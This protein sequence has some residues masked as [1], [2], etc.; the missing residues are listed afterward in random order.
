MQTHESPRQPTQAHE[1]QQRKAAAG[2]GQGSRRDTSRAFQVC[3]FIAFEKN[4]L[5][6]STGVA[7]PQCRPMQAHDSPRQ[8]SHG[9]DSQRKPTQAH[10]SQRS[11][12]AAE[13][14]QGSRRDT[15]QAFQVCFFKKKKKNSIDSTYRCTNEPMQA[16]ESPRQPSQAH[17]SQARPTI[18]NKSQR[19]P[20]KANVVKQQQGGAK[21]RDA[22]CLEPFRY[23]FFISFLKN[24][25]D[26]SY[27]CGQPPM[28]AN[29]GPRKP[30][31]RPTTA[32]D[33]QAMPTIAN[34]SQPRHTKAN[35]T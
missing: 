24:S 12:A 33:S 22:T 11:K 10:E 9:H 26:S 28:Q 35:P 27:R 14:G 20:T 13:R 15:S 5:I 19:R 21:A 34:E 1:S 17:D 3:I 6:L 18:A 31:A 30:T 8:P 4:L 32:H 29:A 7:N 16:Y 23:V 25:I 2:S